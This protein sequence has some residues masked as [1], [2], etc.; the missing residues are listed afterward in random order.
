M[1]IVLPYQSL[2]VI[3]VGNRFRNCEMNR[4]QAFDNDV[5]ILFFNECNWHYMNG[6]TAKC[7]YQSS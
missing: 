5:V 3:L 7:V 4:L 1:D 6:V 2:L